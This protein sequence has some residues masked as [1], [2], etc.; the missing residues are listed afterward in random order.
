MADGL[1][2]RFLEDPYGFLQT[3]PLTTALISMP[4]VAPAA[5]LEP[6]AGRSNFD[7][8]RTALA[9]EDNGVALL[10][11]ATHAFRDIP[12]PAYWLPQGR[13][14]DVPTVDPP[15]RL[16]FTPE[17][18]GC[19]IYIDEINLLRSRVFHIQCAHEAAEYTGGNRGGKRLK[20]AD[21]RHYG[22]VPSV[23]GPPHPRRVRTTRVNAVMVHWDTEW[24]IVLQG[25]TGI[26]PGTREGRLVL[27]PGPPQQVD[28]VVAI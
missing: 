19:K 26:G 27:P 24:H 23:D 1:N 12:I 21:S 28:S 20:T 2:R 18:S 6:P 17:L 11:A 3:F 10:P 9:P 14:I 4:V 8:V 7:L 25:L 13:H 22:G 15:A 5:S 16:I